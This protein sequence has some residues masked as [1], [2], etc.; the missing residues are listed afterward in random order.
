MV[1]ID[2]A[3]IRDLGGMAKIVKRLRSRIALPMHASGWAKP[4]D[5][6]ALP[7]DDFDYKY[8]AGY[9]MKHRYLS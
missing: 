8:L 6:T 4:A 2:G 3:M 9:F 7:G 5:F 1:P